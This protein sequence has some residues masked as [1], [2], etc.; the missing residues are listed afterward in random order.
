MQKHSPSLD[1]LLQDS[2]ARSRL[3]TLA[4]TLAAELTSM[5]D[6]STLD[7]E[8]SG[9]QLD[10][11][12]TS[13]RRQRFSAALEQSL[14]DE[15]ALK[16]HAGNLSL[17]YANCVPEYAAQVGSLQ[18]DAYGLHIRLSEFDTAQIAGALAF[19]V[20]NGPTL[21]SL[22]GYGAESFPS[23]QQLRATLLTFLNTPTLRNALLSNTEQRQQD[24]LLDIERSDDLF[25][26]AFEAT[27]LILLPVAS[28]F[29]YALDSQVNKQYEDVR[30]AFD[31]GGG[32]VLP[33]LIDGVPMR[34]RFGPAAM[35]EQWDIHQQ[36]RLHHQRLPGW[37]KDAPTKEQR[38]YLQSLAD[39]DQLRAVLASAMEGAASAEQFAQLRL[40]S[41]FASDLGYDLDPARVQISTQR[42]LPL[43]GETWETRRSLSQLALYGLHSNDLQPG[44][45]FQQGSHFSL[46]GQPLGDNFSK[47]T[48]TYFGALVDELELRSVFGEVQRRTYGKSQVVQLMRQVQHLLIIAE[49]HRARLQG[50]IRPEDSQLI[51]Q[52]GQPTDTLQFQQLKLNGRDLLG[53]VLLFRRLGAD[54]NTERLLMFTADSP[55]E[56][57]FQ[58]FD[59]ESQLL[60]E[61]VSWSATEPLKNYLL[62]QVN[63]D[64]RQALGNQLFELRRKPEPSADFL[65]FVSH[66][67]YSDALYA[68][69]TAA[70]QVKLAEQVAHTPG[71]YLSAS[72]AQRRELLTLEE[73]LAGARASYQARPDA[74]VPSF[75]D[76]V[77]QRASEKIN[78]LL[79]LPAGS[80]DPDT[81]I[82][83]SPRETLTYTQ[84][85]RHGYDESLG[86]LNADAATT[87]TFKGPEGINLAPLSPQSVASSVRG[88]WVSDAYVTHV[89]ATLLDPTSTG[90]AYRRATCL[91]I[92]Q[93][94]MQAAAL[95]CLLT[96]EIDEPQ[97][98]W[99]KASI[100]ALPLN[101][102]RSRRRYP[103][104]ALQFRLENH[105]L[106]AVSANLGDLPGSL[107]QV[108]NNVQSE[109]A[110]KI[111][112]LETAQGCYILSP[113]ATRNPLHALLYTP[114]APDGR[115]FRKLSEFVNSLKRDG[116][117]DYYKDRCRLKANRDMA[118]FFIDMKTRHGSLPPAL[119]ATPLAN[120]LEVCFDRVVQRKIRNVEE[121]TEGRSDMLA[122]QIW[123]GIELVAIAVT[124]PFPL[125]SFTVG[126]LLAMRDNARAL[127]AL[128]EGDRDA[129][130]VYVIY[131]LLNTLG[132]FGDLHSG[133]KFF[134]G[135]LRLLARKAGQSAELAK[136][137]AL[138][139]GASKGDTLQPVLIQGEQFWAGT[140]G[141][142]GHA[143]LFRG[144]PHDPEKLL[145]TGRFAEKDLAGTWQPVHQHSNRTLNSDLNHANPAFAVKQS[146]A[147]STLLGATHGK[148]VYAAAGNHYIALDD[149]V[150]QVQYD[151]RMGLWNIVDPANPY[152]FFGK[153][154]VRIGDDGRWQII[155]RLQLRG[156]VN[157][158]FVP[159]ETSGA[160]NASTAS[161][162][163]R[164]EMPREW[165]L[166]IHPIV[167][168]Q[169]DA[170]YLSDPIMGPTFVELYKRGRQ[171]YTARRKALQ[172]DALSFFDAAPPVPTMRPAL[173]E[174]ATADDL[175][176]TVFSTHTGM[177]ISEV[178]GSVASKQ[179]L[180]DNMGRLSHEEV[181]VLYVE[182]VLSD[183]HRD[184]LL[185]YHA[186]GSRTKSGSHQ[187]RSYLQY[188]NDGALLN[189]SSK[190]DYYHLIKKAH[191]FGI[192][193]KP[194]NSSVSYDFVNSPSPGAPGDSTTLRN[195]STFYGSS[196]I[197][198]DVAAAPG[199][200]WVAL[201]DQKI[202]TSWQGYPGISELH[203]ATSVR[204]VDV[205]GDQ[206]QR[207]IRKSG[208][209]DFTVEIASATATPSSQ[210]ARQIEPLD[211][212]L[213]DY[214]DGTVPTGEHGLRLNDGGQWVRADVSQWRTNREPNALQRSLAIGNYQIADELSPTLHRLAYFE[215][216]GLNI[217]YGLDD[218]QMTLVRNQF[219]SL[220]TRLQ[221]DARRV[222]EPPPARP[223]LPQLEPNLAHSEL[224]D[225]LYDATSGVVI[226]E[227]HSAVASKKFI[228]DNLPQLSRKNVK[229]LY[230]EHVQTDLHQLDLDYFH[231]TGLM[232]KRLLRDLKA[233]D[234]G[235]KTDPHGVY[236]FEQLII[237]AREHGLEVR[238][239][240]CAASYHLGHM[241][242]SA[243]TSRQQM[244]NY[245]A[246]LVMR[247]HQEVIGAHRWIA[248]VGESHAN[249]F[250][251]LV[252]G[253][254]ELEQGISLRIVDVAPGESFG[255]LPDPGRMATINVGTEQVFVQN[256]F[257]LG[258]ATQVNRLPDA[259]PIEVPIEVRLHSPGLYLI[260]ET[261]HSH[262]VLVHR[263]RNNLIER[264]PIRANHKGKLYIERPDWRALHMRPF[265]D[266]SRLIEALDDI[267]L[268]RVN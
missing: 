105:L 20:D 212:A 155:D 237:K 136:A 254:A 160:T 21:L 65:G 184:K 63:P 69:T 2:S 134:G 52:L 221:R 142:K 214:L 58:G 119:P 175:I 234:K 25:V 111:S 102:E 209:A 5:P 159:L 24:A 132:A 258:L 113:D 188:V 198:N 189:G 179:F 13:P 114:E 265:D 130:S 33:A 231:E 77:R 90:Y 197:S 124:L 157:P 244:M 131:S 39:Y 174:A 76:F 238:A 70:I 176:Q 242:D 45:A 61:L 178:P 44:S 94:H 43:T 36:Q 49:A 236:T 12:W 32:R 108:V 187:I 31:Q 73:T 172:D 97:Y 8:Q 192:E 35:L 201:L 38:T 104:D 30:Y 50:H 115:T 51:E 239:I 168:T 150:F 27:D 89:K 116:M 84:M 251:G 183:V 267:S 14:K 232:G 143:P 28:P 249:T 158:G 228:I 6:A 227:N 246:S 153:Q 34:E 211:Q 68:Q 210:H 200:R 199:Q 135:P 219:F 99:L 215:R 182:H 123:N 253:L 139:A 149:L 74:Q 87:A 75:D 208:S 191:Q 250:Q 122:R 185:R 266:L 256:D 213:A 78:A 107:G 18:P 80:V 3:N 120:T 85:L 66:I 204:I 162:L 217:I 218:P 16:V 222:I 205:T 42:R 235:F 181:S 247:K 163:T 106:N 216:R 48:P 117:S 248:L 19:S 40:R 195:M 17:G 26:E 164:Y 79:G 152:A 264:T 112:R 148:G 260:D 47:L 166:H 180:I 165:R 241:I 268:T 252:P 67:S 60:Q 194:F 83:T 126:M 170:T 29:E 186:K 37:L 141:I 140:P 151:A 261:G 100:A 82:I 9:K 196:T 171:I 156:G 144:V 72:K 86:F 262:P 15:V 128:S 22:P 202:A 257:S 118:F 93:L 223:P 23:L 138:Q 92:T 57:S 206:P 207:I 161:T 229:T 103:L 7:V 224:L 121:T 64:R 46:D 255:P 59:N 243:P 145:A 98:A 129:A 240:D 193:V 96:R 88:A 101:D 203:G 1:W 169:L 54:G 226:G 95:R 55:R 245:F 53:K 259:A 263:S 154:P 230:L 4:E 220:R 133:L 110:P 125:A 41:R 146:L 225:Q 177:V 91:L 11:Y 190:Y 81:I 71:W 10:N 147:D 56:H 137:R 62:E 173:D 127:H 167:D 109:I 233:M